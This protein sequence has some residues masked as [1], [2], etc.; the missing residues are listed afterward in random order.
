MQ[1]VLLIS[2]IASTCLRDVI[3][4]VTSASPSNNDQNQQQVL[5]IA[6][7]MPRTGELGFERNAAASTLAIDQAHQ[8]GLLIGVN[9]RYM[10]RVCKKTK[11]LYWDRYFK[12][13]T[14]VL[15]LNIL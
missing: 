7:M 8:D 9:V 11:L 6:L 5:T 1:R 13:Y 12:G 10:Y 14:I 3:D 4:A 2:L 15:T